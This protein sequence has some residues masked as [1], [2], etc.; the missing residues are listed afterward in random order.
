MIDGLNEKYYV[1]RGNETYADMTTKF[2]GVKI[3]KVEG[4]FDK[5]DAVNIYN[6]QWNDSQVEDYLITTL[7]NDNNPI[8]VRKNTD[9]KITFVVS[10]KYANGTIDVGKKHDE[11]LSYMM[12]GALWVKSLYTNKES[13][14][15]CLSSYSP[16]KIKLHRDFGTYILGQI[17]L[18]QLQLPNDVETQYVGDLYIGLGGA[19]L[20]NIS[21]LTNVQHYN[22]ADASGT[23]SINIGATNYVWIC[24]SGSISNVVSSGWKVPMNGNVNVGTLRCYRT[25]NRILPHT[26]NFTI[27]TT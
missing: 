19:T 5:G 21:Q 14:C 26:M 20:S 15:V 18:H 8:V 22:V 7:D 17:T 24:T 1:K 25:S 23:Y 13:Y 12:D 2:D 10:T 4:M 9:I 3:L 11:F 27:E 6:E 16:Q